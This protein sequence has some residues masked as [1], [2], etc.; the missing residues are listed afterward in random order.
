M[1][2]SALTRMLKHTRDVPPFTHA[3]LHSVPEALITALVSFASETPRL[4]A[5]TPA[6]T[7]PTRMRSPVAGAA[8]PTPAPSPTPPPVAPPNSAKLNRVLKVLGLLCVQN[9]HTMRHCGSPFLR[10]PPAEVQLAPYLAHRARVRHGRSVAG[11]GEVGCDTG[12]GAAAW[13]GW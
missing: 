13:T 3:L 7:P 12:A 1:S 2:Y 4:R 11:V 5:S 6:A 10:P 8:T 9:R